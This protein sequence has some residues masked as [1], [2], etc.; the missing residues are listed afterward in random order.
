MAKEY[1]YLQGKAKWC[2]VHTPDQYGKWKTVLYLNNDSL[3][4]VNGLLER[5]LKNVLAKDEDGY[6]MTFS[7]KTQIDSVQGRPIPLPPPE[8]LDADGKTP[9]RGIMVGNGSDITVKLDVYPCRP[10]GSKPF[11]AAR[12]EAIK[13]DNLIPFTGEKDFTTEE[14]EQVSGLDKQPAQV[15]LF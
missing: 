14:Q 9:L 13:V 2:R 8:L 7:R 15:P 4:I 1:V 5:G 10:K 6:N 11:V 12:L 3:N